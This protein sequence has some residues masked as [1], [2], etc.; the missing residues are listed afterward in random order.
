MSYLNTSFK[1]RDDA[2]ILAKD[3][4]NTIQYF[5]DEGTIEVMQKQHWSSGRTEDAC[6]REVIEDEIF[7]YF[8]NKEVV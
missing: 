4:M 7:D 8:E 5:V 1:N 6:I 2:V 3:I